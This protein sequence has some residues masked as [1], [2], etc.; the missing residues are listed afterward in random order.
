M[1]YLVEMDGAFPRKSQDWINNFVKARILDHLFWS[2]ILNKLFLRTFYIT[3][4]FLKYFVIPQ[5]ARR[6]RAE[7]LDHQS[8]GQSS[9]PSVSAWVSMLASLKMTSELNSS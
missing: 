4:S 8:V 2:Q 6:V 5:T 1:F 9:A 3:K 7:W